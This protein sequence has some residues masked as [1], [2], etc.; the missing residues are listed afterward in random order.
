LCGFSLS[1]TGGRRPACWAVGARSAGAGGKEPA[2]GALRRSQARKPK[3][4]LGFADDALLRGS[5]LGGLHGAEMASTGTS[6]EAQRLRA[7]RS[8]CSRVGAGEVNL[9]RPQ[10]DL[11]TGK[12]AGTAQGS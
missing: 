2:S 7:G 1:A 12:F 5:P 8:Q 11:P 4:V 3:I 9:R 10:A 6:K